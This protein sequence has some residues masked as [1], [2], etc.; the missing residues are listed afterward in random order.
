MKGRLGIAVWLAVAVV[1]SLMFAQGL[2][3]VW[4]L[5]QPAELVSTDI[6]RVAYWSGK[7]GEHIDL[8]LA[9]GRA[10]GWRCRGRDCGPLAQLKALRWETPFK[11]D[12]QVVGDRFVDLKTH[13]VEV[14]A[15]ETDR[16]RQQAQ[17]AS[18]AAVMGGGALLAGFLSYRAWRP[19]R[20]KRFKAP[21]LHVRR[22]TR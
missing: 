9:N 16:P 18:A 5:S 2:V 12:L 11:A 21:A 13:G 20:R 19:K 22:A 10:L 15:A 4:R 17:E 8:T 7:S 6:S 3:E 1:A 14:L